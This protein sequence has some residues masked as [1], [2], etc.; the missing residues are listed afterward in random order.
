[1][2]ALIFN[3]IDTI[4]NFSL[5]FLTVRKILFFIQ[6]TKNGGYNDEALEQLMARP[7]SNNE[8]P[9]NMKAAIAICEKQGIYLPTLMLL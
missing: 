7:S 6:T 1:M 2:L 9:T 5:T 4:Y 3:I 8:I